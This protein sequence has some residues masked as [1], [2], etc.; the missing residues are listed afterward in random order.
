MGINAW[1]K[2]RNAS[3]EQRRELL[4]LARERQFID[5]GVAL[6][7][8]RYREIQRNLWRFPA[9]VAIN[10]GTYEQGVAAQELA[11]TIA[12]RYAQLEIELTRIKVQASTPDQLDELW[13][14]MDPEDLAKLRDDELKLKLAVELPVRR[15]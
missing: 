10:G 9:Q 7:R 3:L 5:D 2:K 12:A 8:R 1:R 15:A 14:N 6:C 4:A 11:T 13:G